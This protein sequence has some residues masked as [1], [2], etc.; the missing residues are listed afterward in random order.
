MPNKSVDKLMEEMKG[1]RKEVSDLKSDLR[2]TG[3]E[4][5]WIKRIILGAASLGFIEKGVEW[6]IK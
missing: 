4:F 5:V 1:L 3:V 6:W 2:V